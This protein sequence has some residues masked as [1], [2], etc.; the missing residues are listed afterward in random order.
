LLFGI[1]ALQNNLITRDA[2]LVAFSTWIA[3]KSLDLGE[4]LRNARG[5]GVHRP[6]AIR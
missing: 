3:E 4:L 6:L 1:L 5:T 2:L